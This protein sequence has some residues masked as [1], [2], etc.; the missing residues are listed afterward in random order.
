MLHSEHIAALIVKS[1]KGPLAAEEENQLNDWK[2]KSE[3]NRLLLEK[4]NDKH[5]LIA[6]LKAYY[7]EGQK[8]VRAAPVFPRP[9]S[10]KTVQELV[11]LLVVRIIV[12]IKTMFFTTRQT[13][14]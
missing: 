9:R 14:L 5:L 12:A 8:P 2:N 6:K 11:L 3:E 10:R 1:Y 4:L 7:S 13:R